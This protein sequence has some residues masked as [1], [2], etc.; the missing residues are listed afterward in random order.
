MSACIH[1]PLEILQ[2]IVTK[3]DCLENGGHWE[4]ANAN[5]DNTLSTMNTLFQMMTT[6][7]WVNVMRTGIDTVGI[8]K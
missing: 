2:K 3:E 8:D 5:F 6:E 7:G 1:L 4:N